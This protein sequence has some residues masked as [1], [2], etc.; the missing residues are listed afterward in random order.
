MGVVEAEKVR[1]EIATADPAHVLQERQR[2]LARAVRDAAAALNHAI[3]YAALEG[4]DVRVEV[5][6]GAQILG[7]TRGPEPFITAHVAILL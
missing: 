5:S 6:P 1:I 4:L 2:G 3:R 7:S